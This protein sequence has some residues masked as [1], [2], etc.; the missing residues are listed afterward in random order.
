MAVDRQHGSMEIRHVTC[1]AGDD[2]QKYYAPVRI[3]T[4]LQKEES[5]F[6]SL[7]LFKPCS[8]SQLHAWRGLIHGNGRVSQ[9]ARNCASND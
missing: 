4:R 8:I 3:C 6:F 5:Y 7:L 2:R 9:H 1:Q